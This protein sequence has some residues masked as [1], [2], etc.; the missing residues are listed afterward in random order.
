MSVYLDG[1]RHRSDGT[2]P[3]TWWSSVQPSMKPSMGDPSMDPSMNRIASMAHYQG[4]TSAVRDFEPRRCAA[5]VQ[6]R[7][8]HIEP[9][10]SA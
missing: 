8:Y 3:P 2:G 1:S 10:R 4:T 5:S 7:G 9:I 6:V